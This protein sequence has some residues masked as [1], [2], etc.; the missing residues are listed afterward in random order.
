MSI[1]NSCVKKKK[2]TLIIIRWSRVS[3]TIL[4][5]AAIKNRM[6]L[7]ETSIKH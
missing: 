2:L 6:D 3:F 1:W 4:V 5:P 7:K